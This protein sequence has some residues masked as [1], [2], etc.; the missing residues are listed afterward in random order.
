MRALSWLAV[1]TVARA[2]SGRSRARSAE[3]F[4]SIWCRAEGSDQMVSWCE[5]L[6]TLGLHM[7]A[8]GTTRGGVDATVDKTAINL[9]APT[10]AADMGRVRVAD[11][12]RP[13]Q[14]LQLLPV[15][16]LQ[17]EYKAG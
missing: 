2:A 4:V 11:E 3:S 10:L 8:A 15:I 13:V 16:K 5:W 6:Q 7:T 1:A 14:F 17:R 12:L 9:L